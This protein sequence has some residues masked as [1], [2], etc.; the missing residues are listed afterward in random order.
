MRVTAVAVGVE[1]LGPCL[2]EEG[3][4]KGLWIGRGRRRVRCRN[5]GE[6]GGER[7]HDN[8]EVILSPV[9]QLSRVEP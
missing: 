6:D 7:H 8:R 1:G 3:A 4:D 5:E 9:Q 2:F